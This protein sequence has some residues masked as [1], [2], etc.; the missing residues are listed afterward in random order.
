MLEKRVWQHWENEKRDDDGR[1][2]WFSK[3]VLYS[4]VRDEKCMEKKKSHITYCKEN[5]YDF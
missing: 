3:V 5:D 1:I 4:Q 2:W